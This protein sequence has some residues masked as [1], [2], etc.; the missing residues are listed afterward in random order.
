MPGRGLGLTLGCAESL[1][2]GIG[3]EFPGLGFGLG[4]MTCGLINITATC[5]K[6]TAMSVS[7]ILR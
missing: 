2:L 1:G 6:S 7:V 4:L 3:H 5:C